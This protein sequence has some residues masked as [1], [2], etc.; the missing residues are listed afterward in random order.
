MDRKPAS[1]C[2]RLQSIGTRAAIVRAVMAMG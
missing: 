2:R 1:H